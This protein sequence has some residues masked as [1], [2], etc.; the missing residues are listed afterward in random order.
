MAQ[1]PDT[2][3]AMQIII[4]AIPNAIFVKN[5]FVELCC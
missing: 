4:D 3:A 1:V 2:F 5:E